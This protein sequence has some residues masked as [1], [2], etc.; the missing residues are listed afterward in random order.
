MI[1]SSSP[2]IMMAI[3]MAAIGLDL[4]IGDPKR[5][6]HPVVGIGRGIA[7]LDKKWN[8]GS[9]RRMKGV[10]LTLVV[11]VGCFVTT[12]V[13]VYLAHQLHVV[14]GA[15]V[16]TLLIATTIAIKGLKEMAL[17]IHTHLKKGD[18][19]QARQTL[20]M[21][22]GRDTDN[23]DEPEVVRGT[24]ESVAENTVDGI[25][26]PLL[27]AFLGGAPLAMA[28]RA[29]NTLDS[30]VGYK[31]NRYQAFGWASAKLDDILNWLPARLTALSMALSAFIVTPSLS[32]RRGIAITLRDAKKHPS[33]NSGW[34]EAMTA[35]LLGIQLGGRNTYQGRVSHCA[36]LGDMTRLLHQRDI[37]YAVRI[38]HGGWT[39]FVLLLVL[40]VSVWIN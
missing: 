36:T 18:L 21:I 10:G 33:P 26:A 40:V 34:S 22:V 32:V 24:V 13:V 38:M 20:G 1:I 35:G 29:V 37:I 17:K 14:V 23:L 12:F 30:M 8:K 19:P 6:P 3:V 2:M 27:F 31:N 4:I 5:L 11:V 15:V 7:L 16:E 28:Y 39:V 25:T 9:H